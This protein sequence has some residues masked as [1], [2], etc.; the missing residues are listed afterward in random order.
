MAKRTV[1]IADPNEEDRARLV[2]IL[3]AIGLNTL[4]G[5]SNT[6]VL[7]QCDSRVD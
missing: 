2:E 6:E 3:S 7:A 1:L 5:A 4:T